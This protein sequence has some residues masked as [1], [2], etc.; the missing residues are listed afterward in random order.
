[1]EYAVNTL[2]GLRTSQENTLLALFIDSIEYMFS[3]DLLN[4]FDRRIYNLMKNQT[5]QDARFKINYHA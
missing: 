1:M 3:N 4:Y 5:L 2:F